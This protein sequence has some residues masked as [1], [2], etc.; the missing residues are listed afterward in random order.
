MTSQFADVWVEIYNAL[1][2]TACATS[3]GGDTY[4]SQVDQTKLLEC[5]GEVVLQAWVKAFASL[6][7]KGQCRAKQP[8]ECKVRPLEQTLSIDPGY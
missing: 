6:Y 3:Y 4:P 8:V 2:D 1:D 7:V 5:T